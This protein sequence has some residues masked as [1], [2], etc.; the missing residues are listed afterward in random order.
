MLPRLFRVRKPYPSVVAFRGWPVE[1]VEFYEGLLADNSK[2]FWQAH[3]R[4]YDDDVREPMLELLRELEPAWGPG[5]I[6][7]PYRDVRFSADKTPYKTHIGALLDGGGYVQLGADGLAAG[8]GV[9]HLDGDGLRRYRE[10]VAADRTGVP[11]TAVVEEL[12]G[13]GI[14]VL[15]RESLKTVPRGFDR[16]HPRADLL[17]HKG[18]A[19]W[20]S[21][22]VG[23]WLGTAKAR[24]RVEEFLAAAKPL[25]AWL[26]AHVR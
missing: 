16:D 18:L 17:R 23:A 7:R 3:K 20:R 25:N 2:T 1:A 19:A 15:A 10:A 26:D 6:F 8:C 5:K 11:L 21:W 9:W 13:Q 14:E 4:T 12:R 24:T 22:P